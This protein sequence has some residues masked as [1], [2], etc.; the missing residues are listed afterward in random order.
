MNRNIQGAIFDMDGT[1]VDSLFFWDAYWKRLGEDFLQ[2]PAFKPS[3]EDDKRVRTMLMEEVVELLHREYGIGESPAAL[4]NYTNRM[5]GWF[6]ENLV[7]VKEGVIALLDRLK[8]K[9]VKLVL[10][11]ASSR[12]MVRLALRVCGLDGYFPTVVCCDEVG[13]GKDKPDVFLKALAAL[14]TPLRETWVFEDSVVAL[15]SAA[16][17]G[18]PTVGV[19]DANNFMQEELAKRATHY[20]AKGESFEKLLPMLD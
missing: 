12:D 11:S 14:G 19:Y 16:S 10:A 4:L 7:T 1:L 3:A 20:I 18:L 17:C 13:A 5:I 9:G 6:Y 15:T 2:N 8:E